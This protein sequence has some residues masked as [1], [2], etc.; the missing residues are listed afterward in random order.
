[1]HWPDRDPG[2]VENLM[3]QPTGV[4]DA[5]NRDEIMAKA[6]HLNEKER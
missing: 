2:Y 5:K 4:P 6:N 1:M 3:G